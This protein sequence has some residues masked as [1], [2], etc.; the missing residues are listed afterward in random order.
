MGQGDCRISIFYAS[1]SS[2]PFSLAHGLSLSSFFTRFSW[3][4]DEREEVTPFAHC[5]PLISTFTPKKILSLKIILIKENNSCQVK[6][7]SLFYLRCTKWNCLTSTQ[8]QLF[9]HLLKCEVIPYLFIKQHVLLAR[10]V[11]DCD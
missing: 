11:D 2:S 4:I 5:K 1:T 9:F 6:I 10:G 3:E 7:G 8:M